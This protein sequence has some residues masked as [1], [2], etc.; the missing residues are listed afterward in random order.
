MKTTNVKGK[1]TKKILLYALST[2]GWCKKTRELLDELGVEYDYVYV[3]LARES[4]KEIDKELKKWNPELS[5]PTV[6][7][8]NSEC[9]VGFNPDKLREKLSS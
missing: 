8:D 9:I 2:C 4:E 3:D 5:F 6:I 1:K 7:I